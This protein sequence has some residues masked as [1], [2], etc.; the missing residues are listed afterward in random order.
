MVG[1]TFP[2]WLAGRGKER[3]IHVRDARV[4]MAADARAGT[5]STVA[6]VR[7][8]PAAGSGSPWTWDQG[9]EPPPATM[10]MCTMNAELSRGQM[11]GPRGSRRPDHA[12]LLFPLRQWIAI[13]RAILFKLRHGSDRSAP[14]CT[15]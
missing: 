13:I 14:R 9:M 3:G 4:G 5:A 8:G 6:P 1:F 12:R 7:S 11:P 10:R 2:G 15:A